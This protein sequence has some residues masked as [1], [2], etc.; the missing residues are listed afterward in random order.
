[1]I[2]KHVTAHNHLVGKDLWYSYAENRVVTDPRIIEEVAQ[3][4]KIGAKFR[5]IHQFVRTASGKFVVH[6]L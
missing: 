3:Y 2:N 5:K 6:I 4:V 1:M